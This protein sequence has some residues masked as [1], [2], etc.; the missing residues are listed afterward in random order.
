[1]SNK[2]LED[3]IFTKEEITQLFSYQSKEQQHYEIQQRRTCC[4]FIQEVGISLK[5]PQLTI[6]SAIVFFYRFFVVHTTKE[7]DRYVIRQSS[8]SRRRSTYSVLFFSTWFR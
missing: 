1:M 3:W 8:F 5:L 7:Y 2:D 6:A 4:K